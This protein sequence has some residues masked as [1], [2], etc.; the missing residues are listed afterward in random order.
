MRKQNKI[1]FN[2]TA[3]GAGHIRE[4]KPCQDY[5]VSW[6]SKGSDAVVLVV[7][8]GHGGDTYVRSDVGSRLA[9]EIAL[10]CVQMF[11]PSK[12]FDWICG[13]KGA[14][15]SCDA[16]ECRE[17][18]IGIHEQNAVF[19]ALFRTIY[20]RWEYAI[21]EDARINPFTE[22]EKERLGDR[23]LVKAYGTTLMVYAQTKRFWFAFQIGD[24]RM[25]AC[26]A[27]GN[28]RLIVPWD[29]DCFLNHTTSLCSPDP[30]S[31]FR[32][33]FDGTG[34]TPAAVF[35]CS[36]GVEDSY[37]DYEVAPE[38]LHD[39]FDSLAKVFATD[40]KAVTLE[41]L[42]EFLP[43]LSEAGSK[44]DMSLAGYI[45]LKAFRKYERR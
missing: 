8:D 24:G 29:E 13:Y 38:R 7:C 39:Y 37:G 23:S 27:G 31:K 9:G 32:Y 4:N 14:V 17:Q 45:N 22:E 18:R 34:T 40:G 26:D 12:D 20:D 16:E 25:V 28:W 5:S 42:K 30:V 6:Q 19:Q 3:L 41:R 36:D 1:V 35:C 11:F 2:A 15:A 44:D 10:K 43:K 21:E 33:A